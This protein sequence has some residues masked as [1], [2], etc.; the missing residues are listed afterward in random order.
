MKVKLYIEGA[1]IDCDLARSLCRKAFS[2][3]SENAGVKRRPQTV[4]CGGR[5]KAFRNFKIACKQAD[6]NDE[7]PLLLVDSETAVAQG[8]TVWQ[9]LK[10]RDNWDKPNGVK[11]DAPTNK[12]S[13]KNECSLFKFYAK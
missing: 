11:E 10:F 5:D 1:A 6:K 13:N 4:P 3:F 2:A 8:H 9:H 12:K 7:L